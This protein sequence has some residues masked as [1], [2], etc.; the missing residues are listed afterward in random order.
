MC[1]ISGFFS[2]EGK[3]AK[4]ILTKLV[5]DIRHRGPDDE[6]IWISSDG[7]VGLGHRRLSIID[8]SP[9][10]H[11]PMRSAS[12]RYVI[13]F[14]G[15]IYNFRELRQQL[16]SFGHVFHSESDTEVMLAAFEQWDVR[17]AA[18]RFNGMFAAAVM[19][20]LDHRLYLFRDRLGVKPLYFQWSKGV[21]YFSSELSP[22]FARLSDRLID[23]NA[24]ALYLC[25]GYVPAPLSIYT[26]VRKIMPGE[27]SVVTRES[28]QKQQF[29]IRDRYWDVESRVRQLVAERDENMEPRE[30][31]DRVESA[32][33]KS[34]KHRM[35]SDVPLGAFLS[36]GI[37][38]SLVVSHMQALSTRPVR[39]FTIGF[40]DEERDESRYA[41]AVAKYLGTEHT[42]LR[43]SESDALEVVSRLPVMFG[44]PFADSSQIPTYLV[45]RLTRNSITVALSG[46]GGDELFA[47][48]SNYSRMT[49]FGQYLSLVPAQSYRTCLRLAGKHPIGQCIRSL[50]GE[51]RYESITNA[52]RLLA[53]W[54]KKDEVNQK[55]RARSFG[56]LLVAG[57]TP[58][59]IPVQLAESGGNATEDM[60]ARDL[61]CYLPDDILTKVD[62]CS[63][64][65][66]LE[67]RAPFTDDYELFDTAWSIPF[68]YKANERGGK[69]VLKDALARHL[70]RDLFDR[71]KKGFAVPLMQWLQGPLQGW[72]LD[73]LSSHIISGA[74]ILDRLNVAKVAKRAAKSEWYSTKLWYLCVFQHWLMSFHGTR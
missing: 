7:M 10:G 21:L 11:Q 1:G 54:R 29:E 65:V 45:S 60:M 52:L 33:E 9:G 68:R 20:T 30:A 34:I 4:E 15:E 14:N 18:T 67:V 37:D 17:R 62:R 13:V 26:T 25:H 27:I 47:G 16:K 70:P 50:C 61:R 6:G 48:Y 19:D 46:D 63:M 69:I 41:A 5:E 56:E 3:P 40:R 51:A 28:G 22:G 57:N 43:V 2:C 39:T 35:I 32:L 53:H 42:E 8:L 44:E 72:V 66:S 73:C 31:L 59:D 49:R 36:G 55:T 58:G 74:G 38:S 12:G 24:L 64:S 71:P 23:R